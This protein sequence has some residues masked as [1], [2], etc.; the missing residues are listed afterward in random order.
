LGLG[1]YPTVSLAQARERAQAARLLLQSGTDPVAARRGQRN[2]AVLSAANAISFKAA[3]DAYIKAH[4][5]KWGVKSIGQWTN[6]LATYAYPIIGT[7]PVRQI[8]TSL[9]LKVLEPIWVSK[10]VT[11]TRV[12]GRIEKILDWGKVHGYCEGENPARWTGHLDQL[13]PTKIVTATHYA[14]M[15]Y[16]EVPAFLVE[17]RKYSNIAAPAL[18][19]TILTA[20]RSEEV[21]GAPWSEIDLHARTWTIP[22]ER[23]KGGK[24]HRV[25][26]SDVAVALLRKMPGPHTGFVFP[27]ANAGRPM[28]AM[29]MYTLLKGMGC[30]ETV[31]G[32]RSAFRDWADERTSYP[33][34]IVEQALAHLVGSKVQRAYRRNDM[35]VR[36]VRLMQE[37]ADFCVGKAAPAAEVVELRRA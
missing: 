14:A 36:R 19:F 10:H 5:P 37:W 16:S 21:L 7:L 29:G 28:T 2:A 32:F 26:L 17:L 24:E 20:A 12:R 31:H 3:T 1:G 35:F 25:P 15:P 30:H 6:S 23:M 27:G 33:D 34:A 4:G 8:N 11:A 9:V 13:L 18:E 22:T